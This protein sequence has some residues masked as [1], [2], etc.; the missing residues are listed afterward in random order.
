MSSDWWRSWILSCD[1]SRLIL[2]HLGFLSLPA[3]RAAV[4]SPVPRLVVLDNDSERFC[5]DLAALEQRVA[6][7]NAQLAE[8]NAAMEKE[9]CCLLSCTEFVAHFLPRQT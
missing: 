3:L 4:D 2:S 8:E 5:A 9:V 1:W 6:R 7:D